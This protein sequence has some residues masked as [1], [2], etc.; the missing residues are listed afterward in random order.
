MHL[1]I[2]APESE[3]FRGWDGDE[4]ERRG[5]GMVNDAERVKLI[6]STH[7][8]YPPSLLLCLRIITGSK[9]RPLRGK[10]FVLPG[11][12]QNFRSPDPPALLSQES[13]NTTNSGWK[14]PRSRCNVLRRTWTSKTVRTFSYV[15]VLPV[16][17]FCGGSGRLLLCPLLHTV[18]VYSC[19]KVLSLV[20]SAV[21]LIKA[22]SDTS[23]DRWSG[24]KKLWET[25]V[26]QGR[27]GVLLRTKDDTL[28]RWARFFGTLVAIP[29][30]EPSCTAPIEP[31]RAT[32]RSIV[33]TIV[34]FHAS[35]RDEMFMKYVTEVQWRS[36]VGEIPGSATKNVSSKCVSWASA[37]C[38]EKCHDH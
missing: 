3:N 12:Q 7:H 15:G 21:I 36:K 23:G 20:A 33:H 6:V 2:R 32:A 17:G 24:R 14:T 9:A 31:C 30:A 16:L 37:T 19:Q 38:Y 34:F 13:R 29:Q 27:Y 35:C 11:R 22:F 26:R 25:S 1:A 8:A 18:H 4:I 10:R 28:Q 5:N